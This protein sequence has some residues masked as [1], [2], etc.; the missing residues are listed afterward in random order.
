VED[1][2]IV[3]CE[4]QI[5]Q[6]TEYLGQRWSGRSSVHTHCVTYEPNSVQRHAIDL[7]GVW[8]NWRHL[9][10]LP[11]LLLVVAI[12]VSVAAVLI[13]ALIGKAMQKFS[14][15]D[16]VLLLLESHPLAVI[17]ALVFVTLAINYVFTYRMVEEV[18]LH[19]AIRQKRKLP[20][21]VQLEVRKIKTGQSDS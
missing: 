8:C 14:G 1:V 12:G 13:G 6:S 16:E 19:R 5:V 4:S 20:S 17:G 7:R 3:H 2:V 18:L 21:S 10:Y 11:V 9:L 15:R